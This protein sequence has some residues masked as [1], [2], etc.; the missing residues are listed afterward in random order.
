MLEVDDARL[1]PATVPPERKGSFLFGIAVHLGPAGLFILLFQ[2]T[3]RSQAW[4][5]PVFLLAS[6]SALFMILGAEKSSSSVSL[7]PLSLRDVIAGIG[8]V[9]VTG[10]GIGTAVVAAGQ[11]L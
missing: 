6:L 5:L 1:T 10:A 3:G 11:W 8:L 7:D 4:L 9:F 2:A